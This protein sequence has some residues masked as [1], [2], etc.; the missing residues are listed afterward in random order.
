MFLSRLDEKRG[1][2]G[3]SRGVDTVSYALSNDDP[4]IAA[5]HMNSSAAGISTLMFLLIRNHTCM[6]PQLYPSHS[7]RRNQQ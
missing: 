3:S 6:R 4:L 1:D 2:G 5:R 7:G